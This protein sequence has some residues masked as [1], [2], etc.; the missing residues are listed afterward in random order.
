MARRVTWRYWG[1]PTAWASGK[2]GRYWPPGP[3]SGWRPTTYTVTVRLH[4]IQAHHGQPSY[5]KMA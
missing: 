3:I 4:D 5:R 2:L 1:S